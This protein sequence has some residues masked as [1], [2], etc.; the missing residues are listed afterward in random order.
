MDTHTANTKLKFKRWPELRS[1]YI[2]EWASLLDLSKEYDG[3]ISYNAIADRCK[4][5][6]W[7]R[8][9]DEHWAQVGQDY[10][11]LITAK[12]IEAQKMML[13]GANMLLEKGNEALKTHFYELESKGEV[14]SLKEARDT[15][16][17]GFKILAY[18]ID[19][20][21]NDPRY[22]YQDGSQADRDVAM[23]WMKSYFELLHANGTIK[24]NYE[25]EPNDGT[26]NSIRSQATG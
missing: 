21:D 20:H 24:E 8:Q 7:V 1:K 6:E 14:I 19:K 17:L 11:A 4:A 10:G 26:S 3:Q 12:K 22:N 13:E 5:E 25:Y 18:F 9:R 15:L 23:M 2:Y 16:F